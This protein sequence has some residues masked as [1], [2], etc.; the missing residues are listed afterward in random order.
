VPAI[1][2]HTGLHPD[3]HLTTDTADRINYAKMERIAK[4]V[5]QLSWDLAQSS[6]RP[7]LTK[8]AP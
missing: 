5:Y 7:T 4:L 1:W 6:S 8:R 3:Y 2:F